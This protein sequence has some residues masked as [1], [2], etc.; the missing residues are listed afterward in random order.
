MAN[1][2]GKFV[3]PFLAGVSVAAVGAAAAAVWLA[4]TVPWEVP[5][6][7]PGESGRP[8]ADAT[9]QANPGTLIPGPGAASARAGSWPQFR[10][11][12][13]SNISP[14]ANLGR[15]TADGGA[16][17][18]WRVPV[19]EGY[20]GPAVHNGRVYLLDYDPT[21]KEDVVRCLSL[22]DGREIWRFTYSVPLQNYHGFSRTVPAVNDRF[23]VTLGPKCHV[24]CLD[25]ATGRLAW[26]KDLVA[27]HGTKVPQWY[28]G[29]CPLIETDRVILAPG[30][31]PLMMAVELASGR[32]LWETPNPGGWGMTHSCVAAME[33][34][35]RRQYVY[36]TTRG[37]VGVDAENGRLLW[38]YPKWRV[39]IANV[40]TPIPVGGG[41][42]FFCGGYNEGS[43]MLRLTGGPDAIR[44]E[45]VFRLKSRV[46]GS[47]QQTPILYRNHLYGVTPRGR[48]GQLACLDLDGNRLWVSPREPDFE[49][50]SYILVGD[51]LL[52]FEGHT[53]MLHQVRATPEGYTPV[54]KV[55]IIEGPEIW[56]PIAVAGGRLLVRNHQHLICLDVSNEPP[57]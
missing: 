7:L 27:E 14:P 57:Q 45:E 36:C 44:V 29:Q 54:G 47:D 38:K 50:G 5:L 53:G 43:L 48:R 19:A 30:G 3:T 4:T 51:T 26:K 13:R 37:V 33:Y 2:A 55:Q 8:A 17:P 9:P 6:R 24:V 10:G 40:P 18:L 15:L 41:R 31:A 49:L 25:A 11:P 22:D 20:A 1:G 16:R 42:V 32:H 35:G 52:A 56:A 39:T 28:A 46:F 12:D 23:V 34:G 21:R